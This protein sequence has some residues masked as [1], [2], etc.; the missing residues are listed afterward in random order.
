V[1]L[2]SDTA[3][4]KFAN[5]DELEDWIAAHP[6]PDPG[7]KVGNVNDIRSV[8]IYLVVRSQTRPRKISGGFFK[9][10]I[11]EIG[12]VSQKALSDN[13]A[14]PVEGFI[15]RVFSTMVYVRNLAREEFG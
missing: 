5:F 15:Y 8:E 13:L 14:D 6:P 3:N 4:R 12:D 7:S 9:Q 11:P 10:N 2:P 1:G